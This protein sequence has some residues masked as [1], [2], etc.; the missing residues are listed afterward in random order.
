MPGMQAHDLV[1]RAEL[2]GLAHHAAEIVERELALPHPLFLAGH[3]VLVEL[4]LCLFDES[5]NVAHPQDPLGHPVGM[6]LLQRVEMFASA[7]ELDRHARHMLDAE[8]G[9]A[10]S[11]AVELGEDHAVQLERVVEG[12][13]AVDG[14]LAGHAVDDEVD[15]LRARRD[16][17]SG[18]S[19]SINSSS[20][21]SRPAVSRITTSLL[22]F[23]A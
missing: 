8:H 2:F 21:C 11:I 17:R 10:A 14:V 9:A 18:V 6:K 1:E 20:M 15:L 16:D 7:D 22:F 23:F 12:L 3:L 5:E 19:C 4:L 13:R